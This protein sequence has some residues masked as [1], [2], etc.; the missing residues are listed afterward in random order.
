MAVKQ[1]SDLPIIN[2]ELYV[3][4]NCA[5]N[6]I[7]Q[8]RKN[9][10]SKL[11]LVSASAD[12]TKVPTIGEFSHKYNVWVGGKYPNHCIDATQYDEEMLITNEMAT[13]IKVGLLSLQEAPDGISPF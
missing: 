12:A 3:I 11:L 13:E 5:K 4:K 9:C 10:P 6:W 7:N 8:I 2:C 1:S